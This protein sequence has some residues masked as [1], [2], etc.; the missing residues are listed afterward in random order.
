M[1]LLLLILLQHCVDRL[2]TD[3]TNK[4]YENKV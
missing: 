1:L 2:Y 4:L 3:E